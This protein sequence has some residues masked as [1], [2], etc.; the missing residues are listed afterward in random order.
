MDEA[1]KILVIIVSGT[2]T[3]FLV[4]AIVAGVKIIQILHGLKRVMIQAE[5]IADSAEAVGDFF[6]KSAGPVA[7]GRLIS[8]IT[9]SVIKH[10]S[11]GE[12]KNE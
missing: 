9:E 7:L 2:L 8:N 5:K 1:F 6:R 12:S 10:K 3:L 11:K 4:I